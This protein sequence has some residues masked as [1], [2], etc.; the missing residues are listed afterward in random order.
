V[1]LKTALAFSATEEG[2]RGLIFMRFFLHE[3]VEIK[4]HD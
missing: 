2:W 1:G 3:R 4:L